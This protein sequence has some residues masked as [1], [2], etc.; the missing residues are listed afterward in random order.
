MTEPSSG[1]DLYKPKL[2]K[3]NKLKHETSKNRAFVH[4]EY[5]MTSLKQDTGKVG[6]TS[7]ALKTSKAENSFLGV[8]INDI[9]N[10]YGNDGGPSSQRNT[11][12]SNNYV[13]KCKGSPLSNCKYADLSR[14]SENNLYFNRQASKQGANSTQ[15]DN[16]PRVFGRQISN[17]SQLNS[18][19]CGLFEKHD[20]S[21]AGPQ[22]LTV[23]PESPATKAKDKE[24]ASYMSRLNETVYS[25]HD[26]IV[27]MHEILVDKVS[28]LHHKL[29]VHERSSSKKT[30]YLPCSTLEPED[31]INGK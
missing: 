24:R 3:E 22:K 18:S 9:Q 14:N 28:D 6:P 12:R 16:G 20:T 21:I 25:A 26:S 15:Q 30:R 4:N 11:D 23:K 13:L 1:V 17:T 5:H 8:R 10:L 2:N 7:S 29:I 27:M 31:K 19:S